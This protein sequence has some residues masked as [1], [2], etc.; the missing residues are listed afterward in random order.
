MLRRCDGRVV[1]DFPVFLPNS[2]GS[3]KDRARLTVQAANQTFPFMVDLVTVLRGK[4][5]EDPIPIELLTDNDT[6]ASAAHQLKS[7]FDKHGSDKAKHHYHHLYGSI[8]AEPDSITDIIEVGIGTNSKDIVSNMGP[9]GRPG[10]SLRAFCEFLPQARIYG[11]DLDR[12][13]LFEEERIKTFFVDQTTPR[14]FDFISDAIDRD[15]D[16]IID[17][18]LH[19]PN[20]NIAT[21]TFA[22]KR[23]KI[24]GWLVVEDIAPAALPVWRVISTLLP[25]QYKS[26]LIAATGVFLFSVERKK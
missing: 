4:Q 16:L 17:D 3:I 14:S 10:A 19:S 2:S 26:Q 15:F 22:L 11:A 9:E 12:R 24:G 18:G 20:A 1:E 7:L 6:K 25:D 21:L 5:F 8:L 23:L 13:I